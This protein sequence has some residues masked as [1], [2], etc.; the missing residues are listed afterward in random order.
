MEE[1]GKISIE[2]Y[3]RR[4]LSVVA[5]AGKGLTYQ[6]ALKKIRTLHELK[7]EYSE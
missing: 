7:D 5:Q 2:E 6:Q 4:V 3:N 1:D